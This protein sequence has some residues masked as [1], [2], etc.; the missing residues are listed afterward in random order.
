MSNINLE[1][2][3]L[4]EEEEEEGFT[5]D[6]EEDDESHI[7]F[8]WCLVGR[9]L[10]NRP[11]HVNSMKATMA[12]VWRPVKGVKIKE[13][14]TGLFLFQFSHELDMEEVLQGGPW[15][16]DN[17]ILIVERVQLGMQIENIPLNH[18]NFW[19]QVHNLPAG[20]MAEKVG[21]KLAN[22]IGEFVEYDKNNNSSFWRQYMRLRV[23]VDVRQPLK[24]HKKVKNKGGEWCTVNFKYEKLGVFCFVCGVMGHAENKCEVRFSM[25]RD[26]GVRAW[27]KELRA[28]PRRR[29]GR[30]TSRWLN[31][32]GGE[33]ANSGGMNVAGV[34]FNARG[35]T[36]DPVNPVNIDQSMQQEN[37]LQNSITAVQSVNRRNQVNALTAVPS[38]PADIYGPHLSNQLVTQSLP[39]HNI[40]H[41][42]KNMNQPPPCINTPD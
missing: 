39:N 27:S 8:R 42:T 25:E 7:D 15:T 17:H 5:F 30:P 26:D 3:S 4:H 24:K 34:A 21:K 32:E 18:V 41:P 23:R 12:D 20:F 38:M 19:V 2:L 10:S 14:T 35:P 33:K 28:E 36:T 1:D 40:S 16:F 13:A 31:E 11:I 22:Y 6:I 9:F 37:N 29:R